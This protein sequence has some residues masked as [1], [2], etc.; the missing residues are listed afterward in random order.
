MRHFRTASR[1][2][3]LVELGVALV[4]A[5][6]ALLIGTTAWVMGWTQLENMRNASQTYM[7]AFGVMNSIQE[8]VE[9]SNTIE[10][11]DP[12]YTQ[13]NS[14]QLLVPNGSGSNVRRA[15]RLVGNTLIMQWKDENV[16]P[17]T[18][19]SD[20]TSFSASILNAPTNS[21]VQLNC[22]CVNATQSGTKTVS[23]TTVAY[24]RN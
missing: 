8:Q 16:G 12:D 13:Y 4:I 5:A 24:R 15:Y 11:P 9:R 2:V 23:A 17:V 3:S 20:V 10:V 21:I 18:I 19:F 22:T 6:V 14:I 1:G 7:D